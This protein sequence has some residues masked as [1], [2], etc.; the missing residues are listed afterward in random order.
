MLCDF[1]GSKRVLLAVRRQVV[2]WMSERIPIAVHLGQV[3]TQA[4]EHKILDGLSLA[5][6]IPIA[7][8]ECMFESAALAERFESVKTYQ[9]ACILFL[10]SQNQT[11]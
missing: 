6:S 4:I 11:N 7:V 9:H 5:V 8:T 3:S 2:A 1:A 10:R